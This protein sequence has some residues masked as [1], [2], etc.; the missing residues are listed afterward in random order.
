MKVKFLAHK[1]L[2]EKLDQALAKEL[3]A[4]LRD[5]GVIAA[6][7]NAHLD[8]LRTMRSQSTDL[9][10]TLQE[11]YI[12][13]T[14]IH[15]LRI[16]YN[17]IIGYYIEVSAACASK[18]PFHFILK[19]SLVSGM[20]YTSNELMELEQ[21]VMTADEEALQL[22]STL[23]DELIEILRQCHHRL[24]QTI[25]A[26]ALY[27]VT[28]ALAVLA[29]GQN[30]VRPC[31]DYS[32]NFIIKGGRHPVIA[33]LLGQQFISNSCSLD[34][35]KPIWIITGPNMAGK[36]TFLRQNALI[37][38]MAHIGSFVPADYAHMGIMDRIFSRV[39]ASDNLAKGHSTFMVEMI[40]TATIVNQATDNSFIIF[41][42]VGRGT[43]TYDGLS[44]AWA[45]LE[46]LAQSLSC[47][48]LF[49]THYHELVVLKEHEKI[50]F[51]TLKIK[52]WEKNIVFLYEIIKGV[53]DRSYGLHVARLAGMPESIV[54][55]AEVILQHLEQKKL[56]QEI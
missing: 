2:H 53:A 40:E 1:T 41:D 55:R 29:H 33:S 35:E 14:T 22:E 50:A 13:E 43:A 15:N 54:H 51:Y 56:E 3:P 52:E 7:Y 28:C 21:R 18:M 23:F 4:F 19:Q 16:K 47:R 37:A 5:G 6:G 45:C 9:M 24:R 20:R 39:G 12:K 30:Y 36:S 46:H 11:R 17:N 25:H 26:L 10:N 8:A 34:H 32:K 42:E 31:M 38:L 49:A 48:T 27:D 44:L